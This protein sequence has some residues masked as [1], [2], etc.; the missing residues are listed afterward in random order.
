M[1]AVVKFRDDNNGSI[2]T[3]GTSTA[4]TAS[5]S[6]SFDT[7][8]HLDQQQIA[9]VPHATRGSAPT[10]NV[11][12]LGAKPI[13]NST[14]VSVA[15]GALLQGTPYR[16][17]YYNA[18]GEFIL[19]GGVA[20]IPGNF[21]IGGTLTVTGTQT[22]TGKATF[23]GTLSV[24][25][26]ASFTSTDSMAVAN[27]TTG[28]RN[29]TPSAGDFRYNSTLNCF[30][31]YN[32]TA[33]MAFG[34]AP[35]VQKFTSG[36]SQTYTPSTGVVRIRVRMVGGG[37]GG[38]AQ[39]T[40]AGSN[41]GDTSFG[42]WTAIHGNGGRV[43]GAAGGAG[44]TGGVDGT[45]TK[46]IRVDGA[47]GQGAIGSGTANTNAAGGA[48]GS[49]PFGGGGAGIQNVAGTSAAANSGSGGAGG[50]SGG[51]NGGAGG[52]ASEYV[53][54]WVSTPSATSYT[55]GTGGNGGSAGGFAG[56]NGAAGVIIIEEFYA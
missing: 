2:T 25:G 8:A 13:R 9:I 20:A 30:E 29:G 12:G 55:V 48:G 23:S 44:G 53:E 32:G 35:T 5:S 41:G 16:L 43:N 19:E 1:A 27:G 51:N 26:K 28:Q 31:G 24:A 6:Q 52:G 3:A 18:A 50:G 37:G 22:F 36:T 21:S 14:G 15:S 56:G 40:N 17:T 4:Y 47:K 34:K 49:S 38:G 33:W 39:S 11:D 45:G 10:L 42:S 7:L 46:I 54:F